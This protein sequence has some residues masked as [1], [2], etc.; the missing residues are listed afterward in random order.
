[1]EVKQMDIET[2]DLLHEVSGEGAELFD[3]GV[4]NDFR[5]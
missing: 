1:V 3:T 4:L 2:F 5:V